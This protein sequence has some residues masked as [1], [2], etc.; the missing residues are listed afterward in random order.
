MPGDEA[1]PGPDVTLYA[2]VEELTATE[3]WLVGNE[4]YPGAE[5]VPPGA[6]R[7]RRRLEH[8]S[9][10]LYGGHEGFI[11]RTALIRAENYDPERRPHIRDA[12]DAALLL[13]HLVHADQEHLITIALDAGL[14]VLAI[15]EAAIGTS[16]GTIQTPQ[17]L[18]KVALLA[19]GLSLVIA[20]NHPSGK[21]Q[22]SHDDLQMTAHAL[23]ATSC[24]GLALLD[25]LIVAAGGWFSIRDLVNRAGLDFSGTG[26]AAIQRRVPEILGVADVVRPGRWPT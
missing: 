7:R 23:V 10:D 25:S 12:A 13:R 20:H 24:V 4:A 3:G 1:V 19:G 17:H 11:V 26:A 21:P 5:Q 15:H 2:P 22:P 14:G 16:T 8:P 18:L 9:L 6:R